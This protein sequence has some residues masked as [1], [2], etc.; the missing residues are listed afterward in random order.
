[1]KQYLLG[2][3]LFFLSKFFHSHRFPKYL[4]SDVWKFHFC[5][6]EFHLTQVKYWE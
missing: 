1:M 3:N 5:K 2:M 6:Q 4:F